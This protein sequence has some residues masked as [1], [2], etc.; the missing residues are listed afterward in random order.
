M[1]TLARFILRHPRAVAGFWGILA[2]IGGGLAT[3]L[4]SRLQDGGYGVSGSQSQ[5]A[6][7]LSKRLFGASSVPQAAISLTTSHSSSPALLRDAS[8][9]TRAIHGIGG[10]T[11]IESP[12]LSTDGRAAL[13][14][15]RLAGTLAVAQ[16]YVPPI[17]TALAHTA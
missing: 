6:I 14:P 4:N 2:L 17:Q 1:L 11:A 7:A 16:T 10:I 5:R 15:L 12:L 13:V 9:A 3:H 8:E